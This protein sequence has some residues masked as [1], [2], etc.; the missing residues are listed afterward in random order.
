MSDEAN[1][2]GAAPLSGAATGLHVPATESRE[3]FSGGVRYTLVFRCDITAANPVVM[4]DVASAAQDR[5]SFF[6][7]VRLVNM[8][9]TISLPAGMESFF[10]CAVRASDSTMAASDCPIYAGYPGSANQSVCHWELPTGFP[11]TRELKAPTVGNPRPNFLFGV[12]DL[13]ANARLRISCEVLCSGTGVPSVLAL[14]P[15]SNS[16]AHAL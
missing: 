5:L 10:H 6:E 2:V 7:S 8:T 4:L 13:A 14:T 16:G 11:F 3:L 9:A 15:T 1:V 12:E